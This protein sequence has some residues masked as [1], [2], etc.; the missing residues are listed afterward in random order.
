MTAQEGADPIVKCTGLQKHFPVDQGLV[1]RLLGDRK[2]LKAVDD[3][4]LTIGS[5]EIVGI[6]GESGSGKTTTGKTIIRLLDPTHGTIRFDGEDITDISGSELRSFRQEAQIIF[7]D[8]FESL[9]PR[10]S[11]YDTVV[12]PLKIHGI[13][14]RSER[15]ERVLDTLETAELRPTDNYIDK[16][17]HELS[18][19]EKQR[20]AIARALVLNPRFLVADEPVSM[21]DVSIRAGVLKLLERL[22]RDFGLSILFISHDL[23]QLKQICDRIAIMYQG[24]IVEIGDTRT[25]IENP[26]HPYAK[27]LIQSAP[28]PDPFVQREHVDISGTNT[29]PIDLPSGCRFKSRCP[30]REAICDFVDPPLLPLEKYPKQVAC[31]AYYD[32]DDQHKMKERLSEKENIPADVQSDPHREFNEEGTTAR[33]DT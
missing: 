21:L 3:V 27:S 26:T 33:S 32:A 6:A 22:N 18:G 13:S 29:D 4:D 20:V 28:Q 15:S 19:G 12:E 1:E 11:V 24:R 5:G 2:Y 23:S 8:P 9:N 10:R 30:E 7:Q 17:P 14:N 16:Y 31:H 25:V